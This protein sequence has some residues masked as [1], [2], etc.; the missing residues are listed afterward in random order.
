MSRFL[1]LSGVLMARQNASL[2]FLTED[3]SL[4][5][6][7]L[8]VEQVYAIM[9]HLPD[10]S[11]QKRTIFIDDST[12]YQLAKGPSKPYSDILD[13]GWSM[14]PYPFLIL[15]PSPVIPGLPFG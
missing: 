5:G 13:K 9:K 10:V 15:K 7:N 8:P 4:R 11:P 1:T 2:D 3:F 14:D 12:C 6:T